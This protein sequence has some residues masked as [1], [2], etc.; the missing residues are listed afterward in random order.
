MTQQKLLIFGEHTISSIHI[1]FYCHLILD[2]I[3]F[4]W[5]WDTGQIII[6]FVSKET[7]INLHYFDMNLWKQFVKSKSK[8][9]E[10]LSYNSLSK[11]ISSSVLSPNIPVE[12]MKNP[13]Y[14][15]EVL[16]LHRL[17][18]RRLQ[19]KYMMNVVHRVWS[20]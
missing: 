4:Y 6:F 3:A 14:L 10:A 16:Q 19:C 20:A 8:I 15:I 5:K 11:I 18:L 17:P 2:L 9:I 1:Y 12:P 13:K 7:F